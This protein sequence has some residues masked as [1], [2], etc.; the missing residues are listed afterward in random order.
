MKSDE[1]MGG[2]GAMKSED[3]QNSDNEPSHSREDNDWESD[4]VYAC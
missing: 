4:S 3:E 2:D 1:E